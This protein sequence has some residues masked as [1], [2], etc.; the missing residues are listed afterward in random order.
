MLKLALRIAHDTRFKEEFSN[1][2]EKFARMACV[3]IEQR[4]PEI[5]KNYQEFK[6]LRRLLRQLEAHRFGLPEVSECLHNLI[7]SEY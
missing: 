2:G 5:K 4:I 6:S 1:E 7:K 3:L